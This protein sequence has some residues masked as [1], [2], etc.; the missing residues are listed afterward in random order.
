MPTLEKIESVKVLADQHYSNRQIAKELHLSRSTIAAILRDH[1]RPICQCGRPVNH[2]G[3]CEMRTGISPHRL[4]YLEQAKHT[5][6]MRRPLSATGAGAINVDV[7]I[8]KAPTKP[9]PSQQP[10]QKPPVKKPFTMFRDGAG[11]FF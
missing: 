7:H 5:K 3:W 8:I 9:K 2:N 11:V 4:A 1:N 10:P 6:T